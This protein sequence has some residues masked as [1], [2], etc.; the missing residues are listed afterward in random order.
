MVDSSGEVD[1][2]RLEW[3]VCGEMDGQEEDSAL[4]RAVTLAKNEQQ[5][6]KESRRPV[7]LRDP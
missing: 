2:G 6:P 3:I 4:E 1:L 7:N 5:P